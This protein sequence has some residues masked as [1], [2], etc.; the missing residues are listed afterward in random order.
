MLHEFEPDTQE[1][2]RKSLPEDLLAHVDAGT[3]QPTRD[4]N[5]RH[6][7]PEADTRVAAQTRTDDA[8]ADDED[9]A[10]PA[11][12]GARFPWWGRSRGGE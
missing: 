10:E 1:A 11:A 6:W 3:Y 8:G 9:E 5:G 12:A 7:A 2:I 4:A